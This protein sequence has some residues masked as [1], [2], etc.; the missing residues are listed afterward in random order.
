MY[1]AEN[2]TKINELYKA[3][4]DAIASA[5]TEEEMNVAVETFQTEVAK[6]PKAAQDEEKPAMSCAASIGGMSALCGVLTM[7]GFVLV[8]KRKDN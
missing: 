7:M 4:K 5:E 6:L 2:Q 3:A 8:A 1:D